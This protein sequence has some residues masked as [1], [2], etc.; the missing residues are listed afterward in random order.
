MNSQKI[1]RLTTKDVC[2]IIGECARGGVSELKFGELSISFNKMG[3]TNFLDNALSPQ[4][5]VEKPKELEKFLKQDELQMKENDLQ[6]MA[7]DNPLEY[8]NLLA[9]DDLVDVGS[10]VDGK[11][12]A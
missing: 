10:E 4:D 7:L 2:C 5:R 9:G 1:F 11:Q 3:E 6:L 8:E 12:T